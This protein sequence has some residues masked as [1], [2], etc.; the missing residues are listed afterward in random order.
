MLDT[1]DTGSGASEADA[2]GTLSICTDVIC[3]GAISAA[4]ICA[5]SVGT[6]GLGFAAAPSPQLAVSTAMLLFAPESGAGSA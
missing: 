6:D 3:A 4:A 1:A 2:A 5:V